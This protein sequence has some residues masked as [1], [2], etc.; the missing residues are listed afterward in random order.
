MAGGFRGDDFD[1]GGPR[2]GIGFVALIVVPV[3]MR[4][5]DVFDGLGSELFDL[6][7]EGTCGGRLGVSV[8]DEDAV[9]EDNDR[10]VAVHFVGVLGDGGV[11]TV[12]HGLDVEEIIGGKTGGGQ[13]E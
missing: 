8:N 12:G 7:D 10:G 5:D 11:D 1:A 6:F 3:E 9:A 2:A 4:V 13:Q